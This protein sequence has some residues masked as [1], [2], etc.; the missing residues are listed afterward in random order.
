[1]SENYDLVSTQARKGL[2]RWQRAVI[3]I[4]STITFG[5]WVWGVI[6]TQ[7]AV[8]AITCMSVVGLGVL[9]LIV[10]AFVCL[11]K[12]VKTGRWGV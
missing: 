10:V 7:G 5:V 11:F 2:R 6:A 4:L 9:T 1:M 3:A 8:L 12:W